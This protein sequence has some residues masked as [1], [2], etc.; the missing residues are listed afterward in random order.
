ME[1]ELQKKF[2]DIVNEM[3]QNK[4]DLPKEFRLN[5]VVACHT[6]RLGS[7]IRIDAFLNKEEAVEVLEKRG[8]YPCGE[9]KYNW[10]YHN[11]YLIKPDDEA[12]TENYDG[13]ED[14]EKKKSTGVTRISTNC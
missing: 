3:I 6:D 12:E 10:S 13:T 11:Y 2:M 8:D 1:E 5:Y 14:D 9:G 4:V 7:M